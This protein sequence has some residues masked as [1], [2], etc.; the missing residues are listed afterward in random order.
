MSI[1]LKGVDSI[2][3][4]IL[5]TRYYGGVDDGMCLQITPQFGNYILLTEKQAA[6]LALALIEF[7]KN[8]REEL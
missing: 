7:I 1:E 5:L 8:K 4:H 3:N 2:D 6:N